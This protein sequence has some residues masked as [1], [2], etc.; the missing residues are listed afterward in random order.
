MPGRDRTHAV[1]DGAAGHG[2]TTRYVALSRLCDGSKFPDGYSPICGRNGAA[3][4]HNP[5]E[6]DHESPVHNL[7]LRDRLLAV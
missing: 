5:R 2:V 3:P 7:K 4:E 1:L 6:V